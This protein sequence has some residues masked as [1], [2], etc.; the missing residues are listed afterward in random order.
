MRP[1]TSSRSWSSDLVDAGNTSVP[2][3][4]GLESDAQGMRISHDHTVLRPETAVFRMTA[5]H[6]YGNEIQPIVR[7]RS[8]PS[9]IALV[10]LIGPHFVAKTDTVPRRWLH[11]NGSRSD[12]DGGVTNRHPA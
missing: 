8:R 5:V 3:T 9:G 12:A 10:S 7:M 2:S 1:T 11:R 4:Q 6:E